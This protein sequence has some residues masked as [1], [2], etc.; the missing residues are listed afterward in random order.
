[1]LGWLVQQLVHFREAAKSGDTPRQLAL[2][3]AVGLLLGLIPKGNLIAIGL[4]AIVLAARIN[5]GTAMIAATL[6]SA[7]GML[8]DPL[9]HRIGLALLNERSLQPIWTWLYRLP[10]MPWTDFNNSVVMGSFVLGIGLFYPAYRLSWMW[11][12]RYRR[13]RSEMDVLSASSGTSISTANPA[14]AARQATDP[15][16]DAAAQSM[17]STSTPPN[18]HSRSARSHSFRYQPLVIPSFDAMQFATEAKHE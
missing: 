9:T 8:T 14:V 11:F 12:E 15:F 6:F 18:G 3:V 17:P 10:L 2:G 4:S 16:E 13:L 7:L 1:M 5:V